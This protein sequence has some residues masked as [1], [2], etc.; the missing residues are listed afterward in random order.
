MDK[1]GKQA[2]AGLIAL[3]TIINFTALEVCVSIAVGC[4]FVA[5]YGWGTAGVFVLFQLLTLMKVMLRL[6]NDE[7]DDG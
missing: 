4:F 7:R 3:M 2:E 5:A 1:K 6:K